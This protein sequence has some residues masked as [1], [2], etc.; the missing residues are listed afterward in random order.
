MAR[1]T[2]T[3]KTIEA[4]IVEARRAADVH[5]RNAIANQIEGKPAGKHWRRFR[6]VVA[7]TLLL[8]KLIGHADMVKR[9][10][11]AGVEFRYD[12]PTDQFA[13][14]DVDDDDPDFMVG[15]FLEAV[16][17]FDDR[18]PRLKDAVQEMKAEADRLSTQMMRYESTEGYAALVKR[19]SAIQNAIRHSFWV[20][21]VDGQTTL[22]LKSLLAG[23]VRGDAGP[24]NLS[25]PDFIDEA[26]LSGAANLTRARLETVF[27]NNVMSAYN[28]GRAERMREPEVQTI[29]PLMMLTEIRD[30]RTRGNP[31]GLY[32]DQGVHWA[33]DG[34][35]NTLAEFERQGIVPPNGH[36]CRASMRP[37]TMTEAGRL[38]LL[39]ESGGLNHTA[40]R[41]RN[42]NR[43]KL[44]DDG[45][46]PDK[47]WNH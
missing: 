10:E 1:L 36:Q 3:Q 4:L 28:S 29:M 38:G 21:D 20:S 43:Q 6:V 8:S 39:A 15:E 25:L 13:R 31:H 37:I 24:A 47:G 5:Y 46:Y 7:R 41:E 33:M 16:Q 35:V 30:R 9:A 2:K 23:V 26:Q 44:I 12:D 14:L 11:L 40:I 42:G 22:N 19:S 17:D 27:R 18:V 34:Y 32:P 45:E